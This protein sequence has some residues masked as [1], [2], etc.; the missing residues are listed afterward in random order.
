MAEEEE[1][2]EFTILS[3][4]REE[5]KLN[6]DPKNE[7]QE[8]AKQFANVFLQINL[9]A[10]DLLTETTQA[11][12]EYKSEPKVTTA[13]PQNP[14]ARAEFKIIGYETENPN[15]ES[16]SIGA[17][18]LDH[19]DTLIQLIETKEI[20]E[21]AN[22]VEN[23]SIIYT[24]Y[25]NMSLSDTILGD[26]EKVVMAAIFDFDEGIKENDLV[27]P[28]AKSF[29]GTR[30]DEYLANIACTPG[31]APW[32][33]G[34][35]ASWFLD[36][37]V[38]LPPGMNSNATGPDAKYQR[39]TA[40]GW[41]NWAVSRML[42][43]TTPT[44]GAAV[45]VGKT[46]VKKNKEIVL[47]PTNVIGI[48]QNITQDGKIV[49]LGATSYI[50]PKYAINPTEDQIRAASTLNEADRKD[51]DTQILEFAAAFIS[52]HEGFLSYAMW[53]CDNWRIGF[54]SGR[55]CRKNPNGPPHFIL[56]LNSDY[57][58]QPIGWLDSE[59]T[60]LKTQYIA[61]EAIDIKFNDPSPKG[62]PMVYPFYPNTQ[63]GTKPFIKKKL[64]G[65]AQNGVE[66]I[67]TMWKPASKPEII[68]EAEATFDI[69]LR[70]EEF[71]NDLKSTSTS[72]KNKFTDEELAYI[73]K[74][75]PYWLVTLIDIRYGFGEN[76]RNKYKFIPKAKEAVKA[77]NP[78]IFY[79]H[80][81]LNEGSDKGK[82][83]I[84]FGRIP[85][86]Y[87]QLLLA[88]GLWLTAKEKPFPH[89]NKK[90][91]PKEISTPIS[92]DDAINTAEYMNNFYS[93]TPLLGMKLTQV[94]VNPTEIIGYVV[95]VSKEHWQQFIKQQIIGTTE[96]P[97][98]E[99]PP[100][101]AA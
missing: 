37:Q 101:G 68:T 17:H 73:Y 33:I 60:Q 6:E 12:A 42:F 74:N 20:A 28:N 3:G 2:D 86:A 8:N 83:D 9:L 25:E 35:V 100:L 62:N 40:Q 7:I 80:L 15:R 4:S 23:A 46:T 99:N 50:L 65:G 27:F 75:H 58:Q 5:N 56:P 97:A 39:S 45:L 22:I 21:T 89:I 52:N 96:L 31:S 43:S 88:K 90:N 48:V 72:D 16:T 91:Y 11:N 34:A 10:G 14:L 81:V 19:N 66:V 78:Q 47:T 26:G 82:T 29:T 67:Q 51:I 64:Y 63:D 55:I 1:E 32:N 54:G 44:I 94:T 61:S 95:A 70:L 79:D 69:Q 18:N 36:A 13:T 59:R 24:H 85:R 30:I 87:D 93:K 38:E 49:V 53:D 57:T 92:P 76:G 41:Y 77:K 71:L 84:T 98:E